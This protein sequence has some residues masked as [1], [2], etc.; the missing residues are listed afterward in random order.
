MSALH[1]EQRRY[2]TT[3]M[4]DSKTVCVLT[5]GSAVEALGWQRRE[6]PA[7]SAMTVGALVTELERD[8][9]RL[10]AARERVSYAVNQQYATLETPIKAGDEVAIIP[11]VSGGSSE[12]DSGPR[13]PAARL[14][15]TPIDPQ[16]LLLEVGHERVGAVATFLGVVRHERNDDGRL[17]TA[18]DYTAYEEMALK[19]MH[20]LCAQVCDQH[21]L[22]KAV[23][24]HRLGRLRVGEIS[25]A[26]VTSSPHR[27]EAFAACRDLIEGLKASVPIFKQELWQDG[28][29]A[30]VDGI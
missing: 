8:C 16:T 4:G 18:L 11:P 27:A 25:V 12:T 26:S 30:W 3:G 19:E 13:P 24:V 21:P 10:A 29:R 28:G 9:P 1:Q 14:V 5:F 20:R 6:V 17:L 22:H 15:R 2:Y 7:T 23:L